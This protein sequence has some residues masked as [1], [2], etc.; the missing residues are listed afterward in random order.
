MHGDWAIQIEDA[1]H[2]I[3]A[4]IIPARWVRKLKVA[5]DG[6]LV[7]LSGVWLP[8][9]ASKSFQRHGHYFQVRV[10]GLGRPP[11][12]ILLMDGAEVPASHPPAARALPGP[13]A[14]P[15]VASPPIVPAAVQFIEETG[16]HES[17]EIIGAEKYPLDNRFGDR[18]FTTV[19]HLSRES[20]NELSIDG[21]GQVEG[22]F[23]INV[24][25]AIKAEIAAH[26]SQQTGQKVGERV[27]EGQ[28]LT[29]SVG[30]R[31]A[32]LYEVVWK[33]TVR[34]GE[35]VYLSGGNHVTIPY[36]INY[37]LSC[38]V[39]TQEGTPATQDSTE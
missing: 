8:T 30:P 2:R 39:R 4:E 31:S 11:T 24:L 15:R 13:E 6:E 12:L 23:G 9:G 34:C 17:E 26:V 21:S 28:T 16:I 20:T 32:V 36:R 14:A 10:R 5:W 35:R 19:R 22:K 1:V 33:R 27:R 7:A 37:G 18:A 38:E 25:S 3:H 29:F